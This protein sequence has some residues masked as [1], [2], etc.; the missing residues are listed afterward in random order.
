VAGAETPKGVWEAN[1]GETMTITA[2]QADYDA[3]NR[4]EVAQWC[5]DSEGNRLD[6]GDRVSSTVD[7]DVGEVREL[8]PDGAC[9]VA[10]NQGVTTPADCADLELL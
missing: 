10:W 1:E 6:V 3:H 2:T 5:R 7:G 8:R 9:L 4:S